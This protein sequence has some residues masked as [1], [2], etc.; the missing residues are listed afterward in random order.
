MNLFN[1]NPLTPCV[2]VVNSFLSTSSALKPIK[3]S[4]LALG[5]KS[6]HEYLLQLQRPQNAVGTVMPKYLLT[7]VSNTAGEINF[8]LRLG[9][10]K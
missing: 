2:L 6:F 7:F 10:S 3:N 9:E 8:D 5:D 1:R 4:T